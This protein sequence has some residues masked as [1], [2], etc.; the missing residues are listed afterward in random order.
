MRLK[1]RLKTAT[2]QDFLEINSLLP[3]TARLSYQLCIG[4]FHPLRAAL[5]TRRENRYLH[6]LR[7]SF[8][9]MEGYA[10]EHYYNSTEH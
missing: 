10:T 3:Y 6:L 5:L 1:Q 4:I 9:H 7:Y 8:I 2:F